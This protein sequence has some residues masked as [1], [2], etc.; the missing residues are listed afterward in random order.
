MT[1]CTNK[2]SEVALEFRRLDKSEKFKSTLDFCR[3]HETTPKT[4]PKSTVSEYERVR[5]QFLINMKSALKNG[6]LNAGEIVSLSKLTVYGKPKYTSTEWLEKILEFCNE[7]KRTPKQNNGD[8]ESMLSQKWNSLKNLPEVVKVPTNA[9][10]IESIQVHKSRYQI[11]RKDKLKS[12]LEFCKKN[13]H[14]P[15]QHAYVN[16]EK[17]LANFLSTTTQRRKNHG[18]T[19]DEEALYAEIQTYAPNG[20]N[21]RVP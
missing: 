10:L 9:K 13:G 20:S 3:L 2:L 12:V 15:K 16:N 4:Y 5:G 19:P 7:N 6:Q 18:L 11:P 1:Q 14:S 21:R 8:V 17:T